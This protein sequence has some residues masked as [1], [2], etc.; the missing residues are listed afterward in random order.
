MSL[1]HTVLT[2]STQY[3][4]G[5]VAAA[6]TREGLF[7]EQAA[8]ERDLQTQTPMT[9]DTIFRIFSMTKGIC[10][11][12]AA[13]L[14]ERGELDYDEPVA[15]IIPDFAEIQVLEGFDDDQPC[16]RKPQTQPTV[17]HLATHTSGFS[18]EAWNPLLKQY[19]DRTQR[20]TIL[21]GKRQALAYPL[22]FE[23]GTQWEYG[24]STDWLGQI[25]ESISGK[26][27]DVFCQEELFQP[28]KM[29]DTSFFCE[30][31]RRE[32]L[33]KVYRRNQEGFFSVFEPELLPQRPEVCLG[34]SGLYCTAHDYIQFLLMLLNH[35]TY[36][37]TQILRPETI[38][39]LEQ[40]HIG[41]LMPQNM[42][43]T[44]PEIFRDLV[45]PPL[46]HGLAFGVNIETIP[47]IRAVN[48]Q[49]WGG[50]LNTNFGMIQRMELLG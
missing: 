27:L 41:H 19:F 7:Y 32:R 2:N 1:I 20:P 42:E 33:A 9:T 44:V 23:P 6:A 38:R 5:L 25:V 30:G 36:H 50:L 14:F 22:V 26:T 4:P 39:L 12:A 3:V 15:N 46:K 10:S 34:G 18:Y 17:R 37:G 21:S 11:I 45:F 49:G 40:N 28:L 13:K 48:S 31:E 29:T 47:G 16:L 8:G 24:I 43:T 35:G